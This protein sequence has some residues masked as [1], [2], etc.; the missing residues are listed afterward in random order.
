MLGRRMMAEGFT[1]DPGVVEAGIDA[2]K[3]DFEEW[4]RARA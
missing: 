2:V 3:A 4:R 1:P